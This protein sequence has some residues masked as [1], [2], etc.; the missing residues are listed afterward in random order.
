MK[1]AMERLHQAKLS[2]NLS[3]SVAIEVVDV[4]S[5]CISRPAQK[6]KFY[7]DGRSVKGATAAKTLKRSPFLWPA[8]PPQL[9]LQGCYMLSVG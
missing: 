9:T 5:C 3:R 2:H 1:E 7:L 4:I 8:A 6:N